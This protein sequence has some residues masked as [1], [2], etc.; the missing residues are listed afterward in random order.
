MTDESPHEF[1]SR[2]FAPLLARAR[3]GEPEALGQ[4][5][6]Q[7]HGYLYACAMGEL[8]PQLRAKVSA[9]DLVQE[10]LL[11][12]QRDFVRFAGESP[13]DLQ[14]WLLRILQNNLVDAARWF[15]SAKRDTDRELPNELSALDLN[16]ATDS[17]GPGTRAEHAERDLALDA[18][19]ARLPENLQQ[20]IGWRHRENLRFS[21]IADRLSI[22]EGA[23]QRLWARAI[24]RL[25]E[26]LSSH[27]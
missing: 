11:D 23:A 12:A 9:S 22:T 24:E 17:V 3:N 8:R 20:V 16:L 21:E 14:R 15:E 25:R 7:C 6:A 13:Q 2:S 18:A 4:L 10:T 27:Q 5:L 26:E 1:T 19:L